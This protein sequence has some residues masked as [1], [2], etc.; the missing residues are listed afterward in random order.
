V[1]SIN[2]KDIP[3]EKMRWVFEK[4]QRSLHDL[5]ASVVL[6][7]PPCGAPTVNTLV[8]PP[9]LKP[10]ASDMDKSICEFCGMGSWKG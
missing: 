3:K 8:D 2:S 6:H 1:G 4:F 10:V 9:V 7:E 5:P